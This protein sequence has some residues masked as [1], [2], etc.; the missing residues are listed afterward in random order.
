MWPSNGFDGPGAGGNGRVSLLQ[1]VI[2]LYRYE[3][4]QV[5][6]VSVTSLPEPPGVGGRG[7]ILELRALGVADGGR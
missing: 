6:H 3:R 1:D 5:T 4:S 2:R 7:R